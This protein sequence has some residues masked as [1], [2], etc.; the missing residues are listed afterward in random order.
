MSNSRETF[1]DCNCKLATLFPHR[2]VLCKSK[3]FPGMPRRKCNHFLESQVSDLK[4]NASSRFPEA[5]L[6]PRRLLLFFGGGEPLTLLRT[7][8]ATVFPNDPVG[9]P[10]A[11]LCDAAFELSTQLPLGNTKSCF[12]FNT[13][14]MVSHKFGFVVWPFSLN[15][16][17]SSISSFIASMT[18]TLFKSL[19][20]DT[21][22]WLRTLINSLHWTRNP[23]YNKVLHESAEHKQ[24]LGTLYQ[25][26]KQRK[27]RS[28]NKYKLLQS[29]TFNTITCIW[30]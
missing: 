11:I 27:G 19:G 22:H 24:I 28:D 23:T 9:L 2:P 16:K 25:S 20:L 29:F 14:F 21:S 5:K 3:S 18:Q 1:W 8:V 26:C 7:L 10:Q 15:F 13:A 4:I 12:P 6:W 30:H 17:K